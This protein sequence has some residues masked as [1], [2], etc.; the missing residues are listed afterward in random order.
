MWDVIHQVIVAVIDTAAYK[1]ANYFIQKG[2][3]KGA[4]YTSNQLQ[5]LL[6]LT[7]ERF[8]KT[9]G[10]SPIKNNFEAWDYAP[11]H[12]GLHNTFKHAQAD[13]LPIDFPIVDESKKQLQ[14]SENEMELYGD[15]LGHV[16]KA[17]GSLSLVSLSHKTTHLK[18]PWI[19]SYM[20]NGRHSIIDN[21]CIAAAA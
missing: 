11:I 19:K 16:Y 4:P 7:H 20:K 10:E 17:Y 6:F 1:I 12:R 18:S 5:N 9:L 14:F 13:C 3:E 8:I 2:I 21:E 15:V